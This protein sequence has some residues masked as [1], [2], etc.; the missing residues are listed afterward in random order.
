LQKELWS[1]GVSFLKA[2]GVSDAHARAMIGK[3]RKQSGGS[4]FEVLQLLSKAEAEAVSEPLA[5]IEGSINSRKAKYNGKG[6]HGPA[7]VI[8]DHPLGNFAAIADRL[9]AEREGREKFDA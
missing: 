4:D 8:D 2:N 1:R 7:R 6:Q 5:F 3:W 9:R